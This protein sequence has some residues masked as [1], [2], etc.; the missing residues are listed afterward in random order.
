M[1]VKCISPEKGKGLFEKIICSAENFPAAFTY[2]GKRFTGLG[3]FVPEYRNISDDSLDAV[4][5]VDDRL[6]IRVAAKFNAVYGQCEY[7]LYF[8]NTGN[9]PTEVIT[10]IAALY[11]DFEGA[12]PLAR[13]ILGDHQNYYAPYECDLNKQSA[14]FESL[15]GRATHIC[16][17]YFNLV[18]GD[19]GTLIALGWAGTWDALF[20]K[21][22]NGTRAVVRSN[23]SM[24]AVLLPG[25]SIRTGLVVLMPYSGRDDDAAM[26]LWRQWFQECSMPA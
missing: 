16:F 21:T 4:W 11:C 10:D 23:P 5:R 14:H 6:R 24:K 17:P 8:E 20:A 1:S 19:G 2:G 25:E 7:T 22:G 26:N 9:A 15:G 13:G 3:E 18:H 12:D